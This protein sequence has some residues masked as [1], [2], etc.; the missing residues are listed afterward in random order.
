MS[1]RDLDL[2]ATAKD[3]ELYAMHWHPF[4]EET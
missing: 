1:L 2:I 3:V 4:L